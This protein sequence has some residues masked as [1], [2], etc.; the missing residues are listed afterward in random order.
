MSAP[1]DV[2]PI[3]VHVASTCDLVFED[4]KPYVVASYSGTWI[5][6]KLNNDQL[7]WLFE[8]MAP[9]LRGR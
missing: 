8:R 2:D 7:W 9:K 5:K 4:G 6:L 1:R 3:P